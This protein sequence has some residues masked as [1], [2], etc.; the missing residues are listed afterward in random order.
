M[1][2]WVEIEDSDYAC[3]ILSR[4]TE[5]TESEAMLMA[6]ELAADIAALR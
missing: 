3:H 4:S 6:D 1:E 5:I 2:Q